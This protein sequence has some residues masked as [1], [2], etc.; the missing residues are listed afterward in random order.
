MTTLSIIVPVF[1]EIKTIK[2]ILQRLDHVSFPQNI[3]KEIIVVD[4]GST[5]GTLQWLKKNQSEQH[6]VIAHEKNKGK[7]MAIRTGL[8]EAHGDIFIIQDA[9]LEY[10]PEEIRFLLDELIKKKEEVVFGS[11]VLGKGYKTYSSIIFHWGG[12]AVTSFT[13]LLFGSHLTDQATCYKMFTKKV[14]ESIQ[15]ECKRFEFCSE[16]TGKVLRAGYKIHEV[17]ISYH[18]RGKK[19]GKKIKV[20][21]GISAF[22]TLIKIR[23]FNHL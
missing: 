10:D 18:P 1:N 17:P 19:E 5:D 21:D 7:G 12:M 4:D 11:R 14:L 9:D 20:K 2:D 13:N 8:K 3:K 23:I 15:L 22:W 6:R 16:F